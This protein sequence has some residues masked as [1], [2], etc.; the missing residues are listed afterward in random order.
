MFQP[1]I[2]PPDE[3]IVPVILAEV[4]VRFPAVSTLKVPLPLLIARPVRVPA[5][6][7]SALMSAAEILVDV[8]LADAIVP[9]VSLSALMS[10]AEMLVDVILAAAIVPAVRF[11]A[12]RLETVIT[13]ASIVPAVILFALMFARASPPS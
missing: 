8:I 12:F 1:A 5:V 10:A 3:F 9:A 6:I 7:L 13:L 2:V 11:P 4:A